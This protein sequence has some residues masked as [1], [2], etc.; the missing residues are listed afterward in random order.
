MSVQRW[1]P[2]WAQ[3]RMIPAGVHPVD[4]YVSAAD[5][6]RIVAEI[7]TA[8]QEWIES[9]EWSTAPLWSALDAIAGGTT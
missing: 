7:R 9:E 3:G 1:K 5:H 8:V 6:A 4:G 2:S